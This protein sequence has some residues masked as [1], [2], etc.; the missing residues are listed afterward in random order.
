[1]LGFGSAFGQATAPPQ[2]VWSKCYGGSQNDGNDNQNQSAPWVH[3]IA[4]SDNGYLICSRTGSNDGDIMGNHGGL[5]DVFISK[6]DSNGVITFSHTLGGS[7]EDVAMYVKETPNHN[8]YLFGATN[9]VD[10]N[11]YNNHGQYDI[12][13]VKIG[14]SGNVVWSKCYGGSNYDFFYELID[15]SAD[16]TI[17]FLG[18]TSSN[19]GDIIGYHTP[20]GVPLVL[21]NDILLMKIDSAGNVLKS[22][23]IGGTGED[24]ASS[25]SLI[26]CFNDRVYLSG[27]TSSNDGDFV[28]NNSPNSY[29]VISL[30][31]TWSNYYIY[32]NSNYFS[33]ESYVNP[34]GELFVKYEDYSFNLP[35]GIGGRDVGITKLDTTGNILWDYTIGGTADEYCTFI[36]GRDSF[37]YIVG[38]TSSSDYDFTNNHGGV[39]L[40]VTKLTD[41]GVKVWTRCFGGSLDEI[42]LSTSMMPIFNASITQANNGNLIIVCRTQSNDGDVLGNHG[43]WDLWALTLDSAG[44]QLNQITIGGTLDE[45]PG[46]LGA[47]TSNGMVYLATSQSN[48]GNV[49]GNNGGSDLLVYKISDTGQLDWIRSL[50]STSNDGWYGDF[51]KI[52][53]GY[54]FSTIVSNGGGN[55]TNYHGGNDL[56]LVR[57]GNDPTATAMEEV[58]NEKGVLIYPNPAND[59]LNFK[60]ENKLIG[61]SY[62]ISDL[63][64]RIISNGIITSE[65]TNGSLQGY[66]S[67]IYFLSIG[68]EKGNTFKFIKE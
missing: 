65:K 59:L 22:K 44:N 43:G 3:T 39:D 27:F 45:Y 15:I 68:N 25:E 53:N 28:S 9:S 2:L 30:D 34:T 33:Q 52:N 46:A 62:I 19:D 64:G 56:W 57:L 17:T 37:I 1:M 26:A 35:N 61:S 6:L 32:L 7:G 36:Q 20:V 50:G 41:S 54:A 4:T 47:T 23:C 18:S 10:G 49:V 16:E 21:P 42:Y 60:V 11:I 63:F 58:P 13:I 5:Y 51:M 48:N 40:F 14:N 66:S 67:G 55:T 24:N 12:W 8:Y 29:Y 31:S 38:S